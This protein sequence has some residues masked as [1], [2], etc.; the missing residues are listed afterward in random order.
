MHFEPNWTFKQNM[1]HIFDVFRKASKVIRSCENQDQLEGASNYVKNVRRYLT[2][3]SKTK[4]QQEFCDKQMDEFDK[5][6]RLKSIRPKI[7][8]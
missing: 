2:F 3:F 1:D 7:E 5:M 4:R 6:L 8:D